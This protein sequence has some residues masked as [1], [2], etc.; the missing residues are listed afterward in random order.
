MEPRLNAL[1]ELDMPADPPRLWLGGLSRAYAGAWAVD[2]VSLGVG[3]GEF[4]SLLGPSGSG[5][6]TILKMIAGF[7]PP[8]AGQVLLDGE[9]LTAKPPQ[10]RDIGMV[11]QNYALF[12]HMTA[13]E[14]IAFP[15][16]MRRR[17]AAD[18]HL[19]VGRMLEL[20]QLGELRRRLPAQL[21]GGQ[22]QR[23]ALARAL[24]FEPR[25]LLMDEPLAA[26]DRQ[27]RRQVQLEIKRIHQSLG[28]SVIFVTHDQEEAMFLSGRIAVMRAGRIVQQGS[29]ASLYAAPESRFVAGF[30]GNANF[31]PAVVEAVS[32][33][34]VRVR[35]GGGG[36]GAGV[37]VGSL[38]TGQIVACMVRPE[39]IR[40]SAADARLLGTIELVNFLGDTV[41]LSLTTA[42]GPVSA[43]IPW[44]LSSGLPGPGSQVGL[45]WA[46]EDVRVFAADEAA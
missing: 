29:P 42:A 22:Q 41:E 2:N 25:L 17:S 12:P 34:M 21:S 33:G 35:F 18:I 36:A 26:L 31:L 28:V 44:H 45:D 14:N 32:V 24:V 5:K 3:R 19:A 27:L 30:I 8:D 1:P 16:R 13:E 38:A 46:A 10:K 43:R 9:D 11:F 15:L 20:L 23:V 7:E 4:L 6:S 40:V 37:G 39:A